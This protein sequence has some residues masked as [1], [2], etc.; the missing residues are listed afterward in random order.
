[1]IIYSLNLQLYDLIDVNRDIL[2]L[3]CGNKQINNMTFIWKVI[4]QSLITTPPGNHLLTSYN[5][6][7]LEAFDDPCLNLNICLKD[8]SPEAAKIILT[9]QPGKLRREVALLH[10]VNTKHIA[11]ANCPASFERFRKPIMLHIPR[12]FFQVQVPILLLLLF[13]VLLS[14]LRYLEGNLGFLHLLKL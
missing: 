1:M 11:F 6:H 12:W 4:S 13:V 7:C 5:S 10:Q 8:N 3:G 14:S 2:K 9:L